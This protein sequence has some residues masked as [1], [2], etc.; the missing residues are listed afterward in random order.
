ML[1]VINLYLCY[2]KQF[3]GK[4]DKEKKVIDRNKTRK[5]FLH[6]YSSPCPRTG[7]KAAR[8]SSCACLV[9]G[10]LI[11]HI[12][13]YHDRFKEFAQLW[14]LYVFYVPFFSHPLL[15]YNFFVGSLSYPSHSIWQFG[16]I[17]NCALQVCPPKYSSIP[18]LGYRRLV[19]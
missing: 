8:V 1:F 18:T 3:Y 7:P 15:P 16:L 9:P 4:N 11:M 12:Y 19:G 13:I 6:T 5:K 10:T 2:N 17:W 14:F